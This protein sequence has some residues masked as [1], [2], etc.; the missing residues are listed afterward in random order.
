MRTGRTLSLIVAVAALLA[1]LAPA[2]GAAPLSRVFSGAD[3]FAVDGT[4]VYWVKSSFTSAGYQDALYRGSLLDGS[5]QL[6]LRLDDN[7]EQFVDE[8]HAGGG[9]VAVGLS[10]TNFFSVTTK[11]PL[12]STTKVLRIS[13]D[14]SSVETIAEGSETIGSVTTKTGGKRYRNDCGAGALLMDMTAAGGVVLTTYKSDRESPHCGGLPNVDH[15]HAYEQLPDGTRR[16]I[17]SKDIGMGSGRAGSDD[18]EMPFYGL[19]V[20]G[21][22]V[23]MRSSRSGGDYVLNM[24]TGAFSGPYA[25][26]LRGRTSFVISS[27][28]PQGRVAVTAVTFRKHAARIRARVFGQAD[29]PSDFLDSAPSQWFAFCGSHL[30]SFRKSGP[31]L[32]DTA[33]LSPIRQVIPKPVKWASGVERGCGEDYIYSS[34][35][36]R[37]GTRVTAYPLG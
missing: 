18:A 28:D 21:D 10:Q 24:A 17:Y 5:S 3:E 19:T 9:F 25:P 26:P 20:R 1:A 22:H 13:R 37:S 35:E 30:I 7:L 15:W 2:A 23:L 6:L 11:G 31:W 33:T 32:L 14:G 36:T 29:D 12:T 27:L 34:K 8:L 4:D 16:D